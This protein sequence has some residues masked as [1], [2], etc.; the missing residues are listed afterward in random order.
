V[1]DRRDLRARKYQFTYAKRNKSQLNHDLNVESI[2]QP[3][4]VTSH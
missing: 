3:E 4:H 1:H 2:Q